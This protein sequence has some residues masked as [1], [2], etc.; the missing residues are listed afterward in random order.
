MKRTCGIGLLTVVLAGSCSVGCSGCSGGQEKRLN[1]AG[2]SFVNPM[3]S[4]WAGEYEKAKGVQ[5]NY[6]SIG[7]GGG[8][9]SMTDRSADFGC[10]DSPLNPEQLQ[11]CRDNGSDPVHIPLVMGAVVICYNLEEV[12]EP[13]RFSGPVLADIYLGKITKWSD[14]ALK[15]L[16]PGVTLPDKEIVV[17]HRS[18]G[19]GTTYI[20]SDYLSKVSPEWKKRVGFGISLDWPAGVGQKGS[21]GVSGQVRRT[22]GSIGYVELTYALQNKIQTGLVKNQ[23]GEFVEASLESVTAAADASLKEIP[24]DLRFSITDAP[25]K[26]PYPISGTVWAVLY[27]RQPAGKGRMVVDFL[28]WATHEGQQYAEALHYAKLPRG[29]VERVEKKLDGIQVGG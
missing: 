6:Q 29:L 15:D 21:E 18:E 25:G 24:D 20:F 11:K 14:K 22:A 12:K 16:N 17:I 7:S 9:S 13:L 3:M 4:K 23:A 10:T 26:E 27:Q 28:R 8:I 2:S 1:A 5:V 19:S